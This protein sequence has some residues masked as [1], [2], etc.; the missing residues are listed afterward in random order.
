M[1]ADEKYLYYP[2]A[3][4]R[5]YRPD[6]TPSGYLNQLWNLIVLLSEAAYLGRTAVIP[7]LCIA[8]QHNQGRKFISSWRRYINLE[9][10]RPHVQSA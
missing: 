2:P 3:D 4:P 5:A 1:A 10:L 9:P 7:A 8:R 6:Y